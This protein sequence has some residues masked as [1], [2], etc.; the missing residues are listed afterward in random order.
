M[1]DLPSTICPFIPKSRRYRD[2]A[3]QVNGTELLPI[4]SQQRAAVKESESKCKE[5]RE[6]TR[7]IVMD[8]MVKTDSFIG[9]I[10]GNVF[11]H[12]SNDNRTSQVIG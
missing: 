2:T 11:S 8:K 5:Q 3:S 12:I 4:A 10:I 9:R 1:S 6:L 7:Q